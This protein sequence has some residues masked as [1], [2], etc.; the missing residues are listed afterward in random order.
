MTL[1]NKYYSNIFL[2]DIEQ[3]IN[4]Q[5]MVHLIIILA[6]NCF[7]V[8]TYY[9]IIQIIN[10]ILIINKKKMFSYFILHYISYKYLIILYK[11]FLNHVVNIELYVKL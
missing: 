8:I 11:Y 6:L 3:S 7:S 5:F 2:N 10:F 9:L 4:K 1:R